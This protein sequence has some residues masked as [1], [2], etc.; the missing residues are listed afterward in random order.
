MTGCRLDIMATG[1]SSP[2]LHGYNKTTIIC[3]VSDP[4]ISAFRISAFYTL[5]GKLMI[6]VFERRDASSRAAKHKPEIPTPYGLQAPSKA[7]EAAETL[8]SL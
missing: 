6:S 5:P 4:Y 7:S 3:H 1:C 2:G 8:N